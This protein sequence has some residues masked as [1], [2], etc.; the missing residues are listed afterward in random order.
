MLT[1]IEARNT[2]GGL[3]SMELEDMSDGIVLAD[4]GGL[5]PVKATIVSSNFAQ[6][7]GEQYNSSRREKRNITIKI[8]MEPDYITTF[9]EDIRDTLYDYFM[10]KSTVDLRLYTDKGL[11][12]NT[13]GRVESC[14]APLFVQDPEA[15]ISVLCFDPDFIALNS[16]TIEGETVSDSTTTTVTYDG[17]VNV[18]VQLV[19]NIDRTLTEFTIYHTAP[20]G[21][22][23]QTDITAALEAGDILT[24]VT[25]TGSKRLTLT[26]SSTDSSLLYAQSPQSNWLELSKGDNLIRVYATGAAI[27]WTMTYTTRYGAL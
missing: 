27:P 18:G 17:N 11:V 12:V 13:S 9:P 25:V 2:R 10:P 15:N 20:D 8:G 19:L 7:D 14:E 3:L 6:V 5:D 21:S 22:T 23:R 1:K 24:I 16:T 26:R 4:V